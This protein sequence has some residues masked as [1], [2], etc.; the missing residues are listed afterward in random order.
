MI[1]IIIFTM[2]VGCSGSGVATS[3][4][5]EE[6]MSTLVMYKYL[7]NMYNISG[8]LGDIPPRVLLLLFLD[9]GKEPQGNR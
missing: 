5:C 3:M 9:A 8:G 7:P 6:G 4:V 1:V 2:V